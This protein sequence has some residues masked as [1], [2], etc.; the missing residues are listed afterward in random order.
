MKMLL[1]FVLALI[2]ASSRTQHLSASSRHLVP[3]YRKSVSSIQYHP[4]KPPD[5]DHLAIFVHGAVGIFKKKRLKFKGESPT[6]GYGGQIMIELIGMV[7]SSGLLQK[8]S[9][10]FLSILGKK[11]DRLELKTSVAPFNATGK[12]HTIV[13]SGNLYLAEF[14]AL[15]A[16]WLYSQQ[17]TKGS[18]FLYVHSKGMRNNGIAKDSWRRYMS[19][20]TIERWPTCVELLSHKGFQTCGPL[21]TPHSRQEGRIRFAEYMGNFWWARADWVRQRPDLSSLAWN[22]E[23]RMAAEDFILANRFQQTSAGLMG[24]IQE[25]RVTFE[26]RHYWYVCH[27]YLAC[28]L[29]LPAQADAHTHSP[30]RLRCIIPVVFV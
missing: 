16:M 8:T 18:L 23:H 2:V 30:P 26:Q 12:V 6:W 14:P 17:A 25:K 10:L 28:P 3:F 7:R 13:E 15:H 19:Y 5:E 11:K 1:F 29:C 24:V 21:L 27:L 9:R 22:M 4:L 20:F